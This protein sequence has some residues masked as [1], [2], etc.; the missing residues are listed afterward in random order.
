MNQRNKIQ[1]MTISALLCAI[2]IIIP[3]YMPKIILEPASFTLASHVPIFIAMFIS[4]VVAVSVALITGIGFLFAGFP[5]VVVMR[6]LT[7]VIFATIGAIV[8]KK[9]A[10]LLKSAKSAGTFGLIISII[11]AAAEVAV[12]TFYYLGN[13]MS[14]GFYAKGYLES[15]IGLVG[16]G[17]VIHSMIDFTIATLVWRPI[18]NIVSIPVSARVAKK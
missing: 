12:V 8:L 3:M 16:L 1:I 13:G 5:P 18:Q 11:H 6:A 10:N 9:N 4:P 15:V 14:S 17:T 7:H 2:G